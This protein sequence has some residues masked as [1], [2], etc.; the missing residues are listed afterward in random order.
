MGF[1]EKSVF[2]PEFLPLLWYDD[3]EA[4]AKKI[5]QHHFGLNLASFHLKTMIPFFLCNF[6]SNF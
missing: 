3:L 6:A 4:I 1:G 5:D 2:F